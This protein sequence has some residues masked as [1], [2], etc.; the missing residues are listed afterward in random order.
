MSFQ[1]QT[2]PQQQGGQRT[3]FSSLPQ[4]AQRTLITIFGII[5]ITAILFGFAAFLGSATG[6]QLFFETSKTVIIVFALFGLIAYAF[7][8]LNVSQ[9]TNPTP[10]EL[11][12][13]IVGAIA[14]YAILFLVPMGVAYAVSGMAAVINMTLN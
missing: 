14:Y 13:P 7:M 8:W 1:G 10:Y 11:A 3:G 12:V 2:P 4:A 5:A 6:K 9:S